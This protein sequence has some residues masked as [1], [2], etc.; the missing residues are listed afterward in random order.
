MSLGECA[1]S[2][3]R[4]PDSEALQPDF[5][6]YWPSSRGGVGGQARVA[7]HAGNLGSVS[8]VAEF[9]SA[10]KSDKSGLLGGMSRLHFN[11]SGSH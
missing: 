1:V 3:R 2:P 6:A 4:R 7:L 11:S 5:R 8:V 10:G 9:P